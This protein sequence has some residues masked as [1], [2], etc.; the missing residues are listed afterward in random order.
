MARQKVRSLLLTGSVE[1][2]GNV[3]R[4]SMHHSIKIAGRSG[5]TRWIERLYA[6]TCLMYVPCNARGISLRETIL[7]AAPISAQTRGIP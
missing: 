1:C 5:K 4:N 7:S 3:R 2:T 6:T